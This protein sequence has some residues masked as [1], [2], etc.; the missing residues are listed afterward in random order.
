MPQVPRSAPADRRPT[1]ASRQVLSQVETAAKMVWLKGMPQAQKSANGQDATMEGAM[2]RPNLTTTFC[3][4]CISK[5]VHA[6]KV[7]ETL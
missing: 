1:G 3:P 2:S 7:L 6:Q 5:T 4:A